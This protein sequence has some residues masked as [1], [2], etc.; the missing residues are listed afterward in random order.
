MGDV[1]EARVKGGFKKGKI[2]KQW[3]NGNP[4]RIQIDDTGVEVY[5]P[6]DDDRVVRRV[7]DAAS[8]PAAGVVPAVRRG[9]GR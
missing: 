7:A 5:G 3:D 8:A 4:Y 2:L 1:V 6:M 9:A